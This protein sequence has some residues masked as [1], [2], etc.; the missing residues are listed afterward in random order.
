MSETDASQTNLQASAKNPAPTSTLHTDPLPENEKEIL[1]KVIPP[2]YHG[3]ADV[4]SKEEAKF[5]P[6]HRP[7]DHPID[8][9]ANTTPPHGPIYPMSENELKVLQEYLDDMTSKG[10]IQSSNSPT[11]APVL[12]V[13][14]KDGSLRLCVDYRGLNNITKKNRYPLPLIGNLL[15]RLQSAKV[16][17]KIDLRAGYH[18]IHIAPGHE[19]KTAFRTCYGSFE[20]LVMPFGL[21][22]APGTFQ[23]FMNDIFRDMMD[24]FVVIYLNHQ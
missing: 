23:Y 9:E 7:Y 5:M 22:N 24:V 18:N 15:D 11:G 6:P 4:F 19:W 17:S 3:F 10:F 2:E 12:F 13:K 16:Y 14:K 8:L 1:D 21:T 20:Y